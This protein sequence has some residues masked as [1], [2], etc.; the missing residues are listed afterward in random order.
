MDSKLGQLLAR[1]VEPF[2][3]VFDRIIPTNWWYW[4]F[5]HHCSA[6]SCI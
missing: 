2:L 6:L 4:F 1:L 3:G 5:R